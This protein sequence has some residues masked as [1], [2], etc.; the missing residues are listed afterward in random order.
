LILSPD[1]D[2]EISDLVAAMN[3]FTDIAV[4]QF[5][6]ADLGSLTLADL[7]PYQ[8][9]MVQND[10]T[11]ESASGD[12]ALVGNVLA[13]YVDAGGKVI[14]NMYMYSFDQWQL[15]GR[16]ITDGYGP[17][18]Y[19]TQ[20]MFGAFGLGTILE[21]NHPILDGVSVMNDTWGHQ[22]PA[23]ATNATLIAQW[24]D[25]QPLLAV[26]DNVVGFNMLPIN[27]NGAWLDDMATLLHNSVLWLGGTSWLS[28][29]PSSG[30]VTAGNSADISVLMNSADLAPGDYYATLHV[31]SND[32]NSPLTDV[33]VTLGII[34][35]VIDDLSVIPTKYELSQNYPNPFNPST[36]IRYAL[37][38]ESKVTLKIFDV[39]GREITTLVNQ[40]KK[41]GIHSLEFNASNLSSGVYFYAIRAQGVDGT[42]FINA[43]KFIL[44]K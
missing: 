39:L 10:L 1:T 21:P 41:A 11:W 7:T 20:D 16:F 23:V 8:V 13:D 27:A 32:P 2:T 25:G 35:G 33:P 19:S 34:S 37:P 17:F 38:F 15:G 4:T 26:N 9:V 40:T 12:P 42:N 5:P 18:N 31:S 28:V 43:K 22:D 44:M 36:M 14:S 6:S 3:G 24:D 30:T 29:D